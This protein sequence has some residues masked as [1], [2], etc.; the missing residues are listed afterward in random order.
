MRT[1]AVS[2]R[3]W[4]ILAGLCW[5]RGGACIGTQI[6][7]RD[8]R[9]KALGISQITRWRGCM[10][11]QMKTMVF[12]TRYSASA[13]RVYMPVSACNSMPMQATPPVRAPM[14]ELVESV[15]AVLELRI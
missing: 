6:V 2:S 14:D 11:K 1:I 8:V 9:A 5:Q 12:T 3:E 13:E 7:S 10:C 4:A 15:H